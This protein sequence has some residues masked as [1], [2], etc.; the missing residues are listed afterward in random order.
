MLNTLKYKQLA[1]SGKG[2]QPLQDAI[3]HHWSEWVKIVETSEPYPKYK[4]LGYKGSAE[5]CAR[6][7]YVMGLW[8]F[9]LLRQAPASS[10]L[11]KSCVEYYHQLGMALDHSYNSAS[12]VFPLRCIGGL[13][14]ELYL[15]DSWLEGLLRLVH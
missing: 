14:S 2:I 13:P 15:L 1:A 12:V 10:E 7:I 6:D 9:G 11:Y 3:N 4:H 5:S 8:F